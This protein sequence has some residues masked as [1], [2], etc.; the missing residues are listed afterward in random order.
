MYVHVC[1]CICVKS[2]K[3]YPCVLM[4]LSSRSGKGIVHY[5]EVNLL[6]V[7]V[8]CLCA[9]LWGKEET[10]CQAELDDLSDQYIIGY[11]NTQQEAA[12][13]PQFWVDMQGRNREIYSDSF[14]RFCSTSFEII[15]SLAAEPSCD[16]C[17]VI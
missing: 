2:T 14:V 10:S 5:H 9:L 1:W 8:P 11:M 3:P 6:P 15:I 13:K 12:L 7:K 4:A 16:N 17:F